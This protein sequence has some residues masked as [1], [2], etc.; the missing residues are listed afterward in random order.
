MENVLGIV[1]VIFL[2]FIG[3]TFFSLLTALSLRMKDQGRSR[4]FV[5]ETCGGAIKGYDLIPFVSFAILKGRCRMCGDRIKPVEFLA[6]A[7]GAAV[8]LLVFFRFGRNP[9][10]TGGVDFSTVLD[11]SAAMTPMRVAA[12]VLLLALFSLLY[13]ISLVDAQTMLIPNRLNLI[14]TVIGAASV[15][16][17]RD[18]TWVEHLIGITVVSVPMLIITLI[19]PGAFG[20][21]DIKLMAAA[22]LFLGWKLSILAMFIGILTGGVYAIYLLIRKKTDKKGHFA[23]GPF[24][25][26]GIAVSAFCGSP[27]LDMYF[28]FAKRLYG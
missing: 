20:G 10:L 23:F 28:A 21:G 22:G 19:I 27:L 5:C 16:V 26:L 8:F 3:G 1:T 25:C 17:F 24:L 7:A 12:V 2:I 11:I 13:L 9:R 6:E 15:F 18:I 4:D 14:L